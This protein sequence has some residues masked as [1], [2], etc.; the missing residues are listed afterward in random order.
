MKYVVIVIAVAIGLYILD[1]LG[2]WM[3]RKGWLYYRHKKPSTGG[4]VGNALQELNALMNPSIRHV[5]EVKQKDTK[6]RDDQGE[7]KKPS[8][9]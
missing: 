2:L 4:G 1:Q 6:Q 5:V 9:K 8:V 7:D 3:E